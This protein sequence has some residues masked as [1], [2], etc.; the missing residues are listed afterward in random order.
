MSNP[1]MAVHHQIRT[2]HLRI[3]LL[4]LARV[5]RHL[6]QNLATGR[7]PEPSLVIVIAIVGVLNTVQVKLNDAD[8]ILFDV[9][10]SLRAS[11]SS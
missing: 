3:A 11:L 6:H 9:N 7:S 4:D 5:L 10:V 2:P 1:D 8:A